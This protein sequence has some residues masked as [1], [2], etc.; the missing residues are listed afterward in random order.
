[1][2]IAEI[3]KADTGNGPG[4]RVTLFVSGCRIHCKGCFNEKAQS[5]D[6]G[7]K[8]TKE[9]EDYLINE[10]RKPYY[11]GLTIFGG[12]PFE[13]ENQP[14]I[15]KLILR[16]RKELP[17]RNIWIF[18]GNVY[19]IN[20][21]PGGSRYIEGITEQIL[22]N[23]DVLVDGPFIE[24]LYNITLNFRGSENQRIIDMKETRKKGKVVLN[25]LNDFI[26]INERKLVQ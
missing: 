5:F 21:V 16:V 23:I 13:P 15:L 20:L 25:P 11:K 22:D 24:S 19:D 9:L 8:W 7:K 3:Y 17:D 18:S 14:D 1:M 4:M 6:Y 2:N 12:E 10:L 26:P